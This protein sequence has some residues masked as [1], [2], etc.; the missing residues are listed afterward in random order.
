LVLAS[1]FKDRDF[2][3]DEDFEAIVRLEPKLGIIA[4]KHDGANLGVGV[5]KAKIKVSRGVCLKITQ[6]PADPN[7]GEAALDLATDETIQSF[8]TEDLGLGG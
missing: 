8:N 5:F 6:L 7:L 3:A 1:R 4:A 2:A